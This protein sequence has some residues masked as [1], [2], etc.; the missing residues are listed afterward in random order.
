MSKVLAQ[1][2]KSKRCKVEGDEDED[3]AALHDQDQ[4]SDQDMPFEDEATTDDTELLARKMQIEVE[5]KFGEVTR[6]LKVKASP[7]TLT[8]TVRVHGPNPTTSQTLQ[9]VKSQQEPQTTNPRECQTLWVSW[10][11]TAPLAVSKPPLIV[12]WTC[13]GGV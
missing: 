11:T 10:P 6:N 1:E 3:M 9:S 8:S 12:V 7:R 5:N 13:A 4:V 2:T